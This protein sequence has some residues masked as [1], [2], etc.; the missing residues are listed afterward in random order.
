MRKLGRVYRQFRSTMTFAY[1]PGSGN[2][3]CRQ[4]FDPGRGISVLCPGPVTFLWVFFLSWTC[5]YVSMG[6]FG[7]GRVTFLGVNYETASASPQGA[8]ERCVRVWRLTSP[9][10]KFT[11][12]CHLSSIIAPRVNWQPT[13]ICPWL[14]VLAILFF[15]VNISLSCAFTQVC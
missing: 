9:H 4:R 8:V 14:L 1:R 12:R 7:P 5:Y 6:I 11:G 2:L 13:K 3:H 15:S 10:S